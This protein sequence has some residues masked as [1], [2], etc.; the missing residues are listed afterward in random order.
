M[1]HDNYITKHCNIRGF[2]IIIDPGK[3][4]GQPRFA[5]LFHEIIMDGDIDASVTD[6]D[7]TIIDFIKID[8][9]YVTQFPELDDWDFVRCYTDTNGFFWCERC[10]ASDI[11]AAQKAEEQRNDTNSDPT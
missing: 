6:A 11:E 1:T 8:P 4:K 5:P 9:E 10:F 7:G 2:P 3:F